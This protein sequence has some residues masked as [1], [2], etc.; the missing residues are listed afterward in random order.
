VITLYQSPELFGIPSRSPFGTEVETYLRMVDLPGLAGSGEP[1]RG[2]T[3][4]IPDIERP[5]EVD[6]GVFGF[7]SMMRSS[8]P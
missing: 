8:G 7:T 3:G 2:P 1:R 5:S 6:C 4:K